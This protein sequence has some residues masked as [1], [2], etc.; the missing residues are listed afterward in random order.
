MEGMETKRMSVANISGGAL[1]EAADRVLEKLIKNILDPNTEAT[2]K[3]GMDIKIALVPDKNRDMV[4]IAFQVVP[5]LAPQA[6]I[7]T[8]A[9][10]GKTDKGFEAREVQRFLK[11]IEDK[12]SGNV[13]G[14]NH[15]EG[16]NDR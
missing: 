6:P 11:E 9:A 5:K 4:A 15:K 10:I 14:I 7:V 3:R 1:V 2:V 8:S 16:T 13:I 12:A